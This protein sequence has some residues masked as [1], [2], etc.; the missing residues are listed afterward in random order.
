MPSATPE[1]LQK[2]M[3]SCAGLKDEKSDAPTFLN[4]FFQA[5]G[6][7]D[8]IAAGAVMEKRIK[9]GSKAG[10]MGFADLVW[11]PG[12]L[13]GVLI[14]MKK[15]GED[16][17]KHYA[18]ALQYWTFQIPRAQYVVL[19]NFD[20]FWI[21][22]FN[23]QVDTPVDVVRLGEFADRAP[24]AFAF[25]VSRRICIKRHIRGLLLRII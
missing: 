22:D 7:E 15:K 23:I 1:S 16:L 5:F 21:Y 20:E 9:K 17:S 18:Q 14:E 3:L 24:S 6:Y 10:K 4:R 12:T 13:P 19:C 11:T 25:M 2:F 8:A